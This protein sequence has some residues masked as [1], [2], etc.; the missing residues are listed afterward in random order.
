MFQE[1][2]RI[3]VDNIYFDSILLADDEPNHFKSLED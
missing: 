1:T 3:G 2:P